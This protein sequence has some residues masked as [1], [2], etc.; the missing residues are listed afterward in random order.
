MRTRIA[1]LAAALLA[2][3]LS[4]AAQWDVGEA[5]G[6]LVAHAAGTNGRIWLGVTCE[7]SAPVVMMRLN[8]GIFGDGIVGATWVGSGGERS[9]AYAFDD[10]DS[11]LMMAAA[12]SL[13]SSYNSNTAEFVRGLRR[14]NLV[15]LAVTKWRDT[16][17]TD[18]ISLAGSSRAIGVLPC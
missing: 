13:G 17:V 18:T 6:M 15:T 2:A 10:H 12:S 14:S 1:V 4:A 5:N 3:P 8:E 16:T 11:V 9:E 7:A